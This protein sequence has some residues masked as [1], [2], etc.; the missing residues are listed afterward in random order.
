MTWITDENGNR[1]SVEVWG[2]EEKARAALATLN[3]CSRCSDCPGFDCSYCFWARVAA[4]EPKSFGNFSRTYIRRGI[5]NEI[6]RVSAK[7]EHW[8]G[9]QCEMVPSV[10]GSLTPGI[11]LMTSA[12]EV[13]KQ[14]L[15]SE[16]PAAAIR[17]LESLRGFDN[18]D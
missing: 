16:D 11:V 13:G 18:D 17:A 1:A 8:L 14:S 6:E 3:G 5:L 10:A 12:I 2:S 4:T 15:L 7:R 9:C